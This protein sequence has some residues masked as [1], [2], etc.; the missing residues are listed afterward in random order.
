MMR[1][2]DKKVS[3]GVFEGGGFRCLRASRVG[4]HASLRA[5]VR[6]TRVADVWDESKAT[7]SSVCVGPATRL[8]H[9]RAIFRAAGS[10]IGRSRSM[11]EKRT[12]RKKNLR[13]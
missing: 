13:D 5:S 8:Q 12:G 3:S 6:A 2:A 1:G 4:V 9:I 10:Q 11:G 7:H